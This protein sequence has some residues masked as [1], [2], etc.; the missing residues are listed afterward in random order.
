MQASRIILAAG[1]VCGV[2]DLTAAMVQHGMRGVSPVRILQSIAAGLLG[3]AAYGGGAGSAA[4]GAALHF[5]IAFTAAAVFY[6]VSRRA[7]WL[8]RHAVPAGLLYGAVVHCVMQFGVLPLSNFPMG[9][10][11]S[12]A[13]G[14]GLAI[15]MLF[16]GLPIAL[17]VRSFS[18]KR[19][20]R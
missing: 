15:H 16:V 9:R 19:V 7:A 12:R 5:L 8:V 17:V 10:F 1:F 13:F 4:L 18:M 11:N 2:L 20:A 3:K 6:V 14:I